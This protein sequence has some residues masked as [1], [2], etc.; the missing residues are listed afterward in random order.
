MSDSSAT[1]WTIAPQAP[2]SMGFP[3]QEY[4]N[5]LPFPSS[6]DFPNPGI[7]S[8]SLEL[9][10]DS[11]PLS[12]QGRPL[13]PLTPQVSY[14]ICSLELRKGLSASLMSSSH[15]QET[16]GRENICPL[17]CTTGSCSFQSIFCTLQ[18]CHKVCLVK[19]MVSLLV[20]YGCESWTMKKAE[21]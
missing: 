16:E 13:H 6:E 3:R 18:D 9:Q 5:G 7:K 14:W 2:L 10:V 15:K 1:P 11:S 20:M 21:C 4:W 17:E 8:R 12:H 19:A